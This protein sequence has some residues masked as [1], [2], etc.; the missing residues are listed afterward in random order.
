[1]FKELDEEKKALEKYRTQAD[2]NR[3]DLGAVVFDSDG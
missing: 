3:G 1:L 2:K